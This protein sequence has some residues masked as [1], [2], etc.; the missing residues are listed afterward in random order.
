MMILIHVRL[1]KSSIYIGWA[2]DQ[3]HNMSKNF[4]SCSGKSTWHMQGE[5]AMQANKD[6]YN[7]IH[8]YANTS[9]LAGERKG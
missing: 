8:H 2:P 9:V 6:F 3:L 4:A 1:L 7:I 5:N